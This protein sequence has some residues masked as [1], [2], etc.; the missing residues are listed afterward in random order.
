MNIKK[1]NADARVA[2]ATGEAA[3]IR[4]T[5]TARGAEV[6][7][8]GLARARGYRAQVEALGSNATA[9]VNVVAALAEGKAKFVPD[10]LVTGGGNGG[11]ALDGLAATAMRFFGPGN[12]GSGTGTST[13]LPLAPLGPEGEAAPNKLIPKEPSAKS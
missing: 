6:E 11:G 10:V 8:V 12:G 13:K 2:E 5:G 4:Q 1:N 3:Y 9:I 7:A